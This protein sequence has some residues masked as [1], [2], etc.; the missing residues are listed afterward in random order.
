MS[1]AE[2]HVVRALLRGGLLN[3]ARRGELRCPL[4]VV[5]R[6]ARVLHNP[7]YAGAY[8]YP[9][10]QSIVGTSIDTAVGQL[11]VATATPMSLELTPAVQELDD[12]LDEGGHDHSVGG[13][14]F[15]EQRCSTRRGSAW[16]R[17]GRQIA[18]RRGP[19]A[20][21]PAVSGRT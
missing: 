20:D 4:P 9:S 14:V 11:L 2:L 13:P 17:N 15:G 19:S 21:L 12:R 1:E 7:W 10:C 8:V 18:Q 6:A 5:H 3:K 16:G